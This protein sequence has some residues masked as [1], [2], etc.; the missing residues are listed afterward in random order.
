MRSLAGLQFQQVRYENYSY[1]DKENNDT[2]EILRLL[3]ELSK[4]QGDA[5]RDTEGQQ[6]MQEIGSHLPVKILA[7]HKNITG[8]SEKRRSVA[9]LAG[10]IC[11][12]ISS[13][14]PSPIALR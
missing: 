8:M 3:I 7:H 1:E 2:A 10:N 5:E 4:L 14:F 6:R 13:P 11:G 12:N 9:R